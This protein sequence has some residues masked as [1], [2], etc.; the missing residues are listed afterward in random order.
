[1]FWGKWGS[2]QGVVQL[3]SSW[4]SP[5]EH[6]GTPSETPRADDAVRGLPYPIEPQFPNRQWIAATSLFVGESMSVGSLG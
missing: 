5:P 3:A 1:M 6:H 4:P 2:V